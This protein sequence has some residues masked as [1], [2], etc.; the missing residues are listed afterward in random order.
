MATDILEDCTCLCVHKEPRSTVDGSFR[1]VSG[2]A[3]RLQALLEVADMLTEK[4]KLTDLDIIALDVLLEA[5]R[6]HTSEIIRRIGQLSSAAGNA[7]ALP[8][9]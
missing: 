2:A 9:N 7:E 5:S 3:Q 1:Y 6:E 8:R 4:P